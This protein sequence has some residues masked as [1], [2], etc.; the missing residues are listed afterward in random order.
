TGFSFSNIRPANDVVKTTGG[1]ASGPVSFIK[2][3]DS[4][5]EVIK[6]GGKR[7][8]ANMGILRIDH[9]DIMDFITCKRKEGV[10]TNFNISVGVTDEFMLAV[11]KGEDFPLV[12]PRNGR[13]VQKINAKQVFDLITLMAWE[14]GDPGVVFIDRLNKD[15]PT[16]TL[17]KI[18]STNPCG[19]QP[20]LAYEACNLG[21]INLAKMVKLRFCFEIS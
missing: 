16:P 13:I 9:P 6:Q 20:L 14:T 2:V 8:G 18:E 5:T 12:N 15:N 10:L 7:R 11:K 17:G 1:I 4:A 21:S 3:F 19:E